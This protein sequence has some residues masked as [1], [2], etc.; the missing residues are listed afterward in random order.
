M[1][2]IGVAEFVFRILKVGELGFYKGVKL[3]EVLILPR[4]FLKDAPRNDFSQVG[5]VD[6]LNSKV[7]QRLRHEGA[8]YSQRTLR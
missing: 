8:V 7:L 2:G 4:I 5:S 3:F 1:E 6:P